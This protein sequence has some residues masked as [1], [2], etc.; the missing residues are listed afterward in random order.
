M[1]LCVW[2]LHL[3]VLCSSSCCVQLHIF[4]LVAL[5]H[6]IICLY[7]SL[8]ILLMGIGVV[9]SLGLLFTY[10]AY[11]FWS[12][13]GHMHGFLLG[14]EEPGQG[15]WTRELLSS[16]PKWLQPSILLPS[17]YSGEFQLLHILTNTWYFLF[18]FSPSVRYS[19]G[20]FEKNVFL[21]TPFHL[22]S[23]HPPPPAFGN[24]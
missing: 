21:L 22:H 3:T 15:I 19:C 13:G 4:V 9:P 14:V 7:P 20:V 5:W 2:P 23:C 12:F 1:L 17:V 11:V 10:R 6:S 18:H 8:S 16:L 24:Q